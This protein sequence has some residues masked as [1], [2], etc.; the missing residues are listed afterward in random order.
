MTVKTSKERI[1]EEAAIL[2]TEKGYQASSMRDL[3]DRVGL[4][5]SSFYN[6]IKSKASCRV[7]IK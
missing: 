7:F 1:F 3:S 2:F 6:H 4:K 5:P